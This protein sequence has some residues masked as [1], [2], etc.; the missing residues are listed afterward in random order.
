[1]HRS[2]TSAI[3]RV[4]NL[5]GVV[6][7]KNLMSANSDNLK[8]YWEPKDI[9]SIN[10][11]L[12]NRAKTNWFDDSYISKS[13][14][15][16][17]ETLDLRNVAMQ[18]LKKNFEQDNSDCLVIKDPRFCRLLPFWHAV[19]DDMNIDFYHVLIIRHPN[20]VFSSFKKRSEKSEYR[21]AAIIHAEKLN[22]LWLRYLLDAEFYT[23]NKKRHMISYQQLVNQPNLII[24]DL[25]TQLREFT[26]LSAVD[27]MILNNFISIEQ[28]H[29]KHKESDGNQLLELSC[30]V[31]QNLLYHI[32]NSQ[33][34]SVYLTQ[35]RDA[36]NNVSEHYSTLTQDTK[37][38]IHTLTPWS[39]EKALMISRHISSAKTRRIL[40][41]SGA[42]NSRGH[43]YRVTQKMQALKDAANEV[44]YLKLDAQFNLSNLNE[45][46]AIVIFRA[47]WSE[48]LK[49][50]YKYC[51]QHNIITIFDIDDLVFS[52]DIMTEKNWDY[53]R[54]LNQG[55][56]DQWHK[57]F[58]GYAKT[59]KRSDYVIVPTQAL[60]DE[61]KNLKKKTGILANGVGQDMIDIS[62]SILKSGLTK[63]SD[64]DG[65]IR[66]GYASGTPTHQKDFAEISPVI[67]DLFK[68]FDKLLLIIVGH[69]NLKE[70]P[71][72]QPYENRIETRP[73]VEHMQLFAEYHLF[74]INLAP[75]QTNNLFCEGKSQLKY[76][77]SALVEVPTIS[78][79]TEPYRN[80]IH[81]GLTGFYATTRQEWF[82]YLVVLI[83][84]ADK[85]IAIGQ[86]AKKHVMARF[87]PEMQSATAHALINNILDK[88]L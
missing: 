62:Q 15:I 60:A 13:W 88:K 77:E 22:L 39:R 54:Q 61:V 48:V 34:N 9:A 43:T 14:Q 85:R 44:S 33:Q 10:N 37:N 69:L 82:D 81:L 70:F 78:S 5:L 50:I 63:A 38:N 3:T 52:P 55:Q 27:K 45:F 72:L 31:Y 29:H 7:P 2:G 64:Q 20:E 71:E 28:Q 86:A 40:Y 84:D 6:L 79:A 26:I 36:L 83:E 4:I 16:S 42:P 11:Q 65:N 41:L 67:A 66:L 57:Q 25:E 87:G 12:L 46:D 8:G 51:N 68:K 23:R 18:L 58:L 19:L 21:P 30:S 73:I 53:L 35:T 24:D 59:L 75:L 74:D 49:K 32:N 1:M 56:K 80:T 17:E 76:H 47:G